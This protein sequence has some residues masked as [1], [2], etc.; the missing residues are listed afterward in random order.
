MVIKTPRFVKN[1][2]KKSRAASTAQ[3]SLDCI[4]IHYALMH[5]HTT[6]KE[7]INR[8]GLSSG[9]PVEEPGS[10]LL[11]KRKRYLF[12]EGPDIGVHPTNMPTSTVSEPSGWSFD[13]SK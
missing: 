3:A 6:T 11:L 2:I 4:V 10:T 7:L 1:P 5:L 9:I 13:R 8:Q 12:P